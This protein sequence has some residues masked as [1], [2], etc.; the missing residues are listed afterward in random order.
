MMDVGYQISRRLFLALLGGV[1]FLPETAWPADEVPPLLDHFIL[2]CNDLDGGINF[3]EENTGVRAA[4]GGVHP[5]R[6]T[7]NALLS[8]GKLRYLEIMAPDP[9]QH[10]TPH[11]P[12][13]LELKEPRIVGWAVHTTDLDALATK[14]IA[15]GF[16]IEG[17]KDGSRFRPDGRILHWRS[18]QLKNVE[19]SPLPFFIEWASGTV[20]PS[21]DAPTG[22][23]LL[24]F[25]V[26]TTHAVGLKESF[27]RLGVD[28]TVEPGKQ[29]TLRAQLAGPKGQIA[30]SS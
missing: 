19:G 22:C 20:H 8:L 29:E 21:E 30:L 15:A 28:I 11:I 27:R 6:G 24:R 13:L 12:G 3:V 14:A 9:E 16:A 4:F 10:V 5:G 18:F 26:Q 1:A 7:R 25:V 2:G 23:T 17:P